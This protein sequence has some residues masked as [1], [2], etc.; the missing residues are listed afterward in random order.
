MKLPNSQHICVER[1]KIT[2]YL[3]STSHPQGRSKAEFFFNFGFRAERW[4]ELA[5][6]LRKH[7]AEYDVNSVIESPHGDLYVVE[8]ALGSPDGHDPLVRSVWIL[9][10]EGGT[11]RLITAYPIRS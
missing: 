3:L 7:G 9:D 5:A 1:A 8:G 2:D 10:A 6:A 4:R 11:V